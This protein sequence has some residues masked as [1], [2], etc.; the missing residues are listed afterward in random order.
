MN[1]A[2][3]KP[4][5]RGWFWGGEEP[6]WIIVALVIVALLGGAA[7]MAGVRG[8]T[9]AVEVDGIVLSYPADWSAAGVLTSDEEN[10][11]VRV[12]E[13]AGR[14]SLTLSVLRAL[15]PA[16]P[17][18]MDAL[19][20]QRGFDRAQREAMYRV[21]STTPVELGGKRGVAVAYAYVADPQATAYQSALPVVMEG[22]DYLVPHAGYVYVLTLEAP[23]E[24]Y[25]E[26]EAIFNRIIASVRF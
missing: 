6:E 18:T 24:R 13:M 12:G 15:D 5:S 22:V 10:A 9:A 23:A 14:A 19:V 21:L 1:A 17:V 26:Y 2:T 4:R 11:L 8:Q 3:I 25:A 20:A 16:N 7:L